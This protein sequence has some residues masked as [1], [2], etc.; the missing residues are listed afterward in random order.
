MHPTDIERSLRT[1]KILVDTR[2]QTTLLSK[3]RF[4]QFSVPYERKKLDFGDYSA[5]FSLP[6]GNVLSLENNVVIER[7]LGFQEICS[8]YTSQRERFKREFER[9]KDKN[10][11]TYLLI[12][13]AS[14]EKAYSGQ[15]R[16][17]MQPKALV[18]SILAWLARYDCQIIFC[19]PRTTGKLIHDILYR[20]GKEML[21][22]MVDE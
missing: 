22:R 16:S 6:D 5:V 4:S 19:E 14:W 7:K 9:A 18:A 17:K 13:N 3:A 10:A 20:E 8:C 21:E 12:E 15:Y 11:K 2:E 1:M